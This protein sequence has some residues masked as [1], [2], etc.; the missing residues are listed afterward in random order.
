MFSILPGVPSFVCVC[1]VSVEIFFP[2][3]QVARLFLYYNPMYPF[4]DFT[5]RSVM[6][7]VLKCGVWI[8]V[9]LV[10]LG[11]TYGYQ[12]LPAPCVPLSFLHWIFFTLLSKISWPYMQVWSYFWS[13]SPL[14]NLSVSI[15]VVGI[16]FNFFWF[17]DQCVSGF[18]KRL[19]LYSSG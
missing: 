17:I 10:V 2:H 4:L 7:F 8:Q 12:I 9:R 5:F 6:Y 11:F 3:F 15:P 13:V 14:I 1:E 19:L 16:Y 18:V